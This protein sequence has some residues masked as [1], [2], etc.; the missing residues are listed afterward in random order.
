M[1]VANRL[2]Q[3]RQFDLALKMIKYVFDPLARSAPTSWKW[4]PFR[5]ADT[6]NSLELLF[7]QLKPN[8]PEGMTGEIN[9]WRNN[10][11]QPH[12]LA[13]SSH[14][15]GARPQRIP[16]LGKKLP[17][18]YNSLVDKFDPF[19]AELELAF[20]YSNYGNVS[21][22]TTTPDAASMANLFGFA[23]SRYFCIRTIRN[24]PRSEI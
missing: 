22:P 16:S 8:T 15:Y 5:S 20:P 11:F 2:L 13:R 24:S 7:S 18:S 6:A 23:T 3:N 10:P 17:Q 4:L 14:I 12:L 1:A 9:Q 21:T 19:S